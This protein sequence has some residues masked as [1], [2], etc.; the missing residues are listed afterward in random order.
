MGRR[1]LCVRLGAVDD[2]VG[3]VIVDAQGIQGGPE[4]NHIVGIIFVVAVD[5]T[6]H[7]VGTHL[8]DV[9]GIP[10]VVGRAAVILCHPES[11]RVHAQPLGQIVHVDS[12]VGDLIEHH[13]VALFVL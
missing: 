13:D 8:S 5:F 1:V 9:D 4:P 2:K 12:I 7:C 11:I 10:A 3:P 6:D